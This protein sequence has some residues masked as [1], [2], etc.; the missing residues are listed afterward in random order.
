[1]N[2]ENAEKWCRSYPTDQKLTG[3]QEEVDSQLAENVR[4]QGCL[5]CEG[6]L[7]C[8]DYDRKPREGPA[9]WNKRHS[10]CCDQ[11]EC[12]KRHTPPSVRFLGPKV[13]V[14][15]V[16]ILVSAMQHGFNAK[17]MQVLRENLGIDRRTLEHWRKW[18]LETF[19]GSPFWKN[20]RGR[21]MPPIDEQTMPESLCEKYGIDRQDRL[22]QMLTFLAP[23][24]TGSVPWK[25]DF[26]KEAI[27]P[28]EVAG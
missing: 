14:G 1:M 2:T 8:A 9:H 22:L 7:H 27:W 18:W 12:R 23:M 20:A 4:K 3:L 11:E 28:A 15:V 5:F 16:V 17:R 10:F 26:L 21:I 25:S 24:T 13:Y 19:V 6:K